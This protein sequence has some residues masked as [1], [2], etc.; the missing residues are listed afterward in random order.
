MGLLLTDGVDA[1]L[2][3]ALTQALAKEGAVVEVIAPT[4]GGVTASD[5]ARLPAKQAIAGGPSVLYDAVALLPGPE[6]VAALSGN[7]AVRDF[8]ADAFAHAKF[9]GFVEAARPLFEKA[10]V[11]APLDAGCVPLAA[12]ADAGKFVEQCRALRF[13]P[14]ERG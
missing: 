11:A 12:P 1:S 4:V 10:G 14:R 7:P 6:Q 2:L 8:I 9:I 5:G 13:W 3:Q